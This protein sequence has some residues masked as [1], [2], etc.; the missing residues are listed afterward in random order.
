MQITLTR[1]E[2]E[3]FVQDQIAAGRYDSAEEVVTGALAM[4]Q[5]HQEVELDELEEMRAAIQ[6]GLDEANRGESKPWD[7]R[8]V[9]A[10]VARRLGE[11]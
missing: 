6:I 2:L 10:D 7:P 5:A 11:K 8:E 1:P 9:S 4:L 3:K